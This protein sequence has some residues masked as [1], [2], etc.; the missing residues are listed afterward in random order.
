MTNRNPTLYR[1]IA[2]GSALS[3][4]FA[5]GGS[6]GGGRN[7]GRPSGT[8]SFPPSDDSVTDADSI[9]VR[10]TADDRRDVTGVTVNGVVATTSDTFAHWEA[11]VPLVSTP[12]ELS[13]DI[14]AQGNR[15]RLDAVTRTIHVS[16]KVL[17]TPRDV[18]LG[19]TTGDL[20]ILDSFHRGLFRQDLATS[21]RTLVSDD[22]QGTGFAL[23]LP[24][25]ILID[26]TNSRAFLSNGSP[27]AIVEIDLLTGD[28]AEFSGPTRGAG[29]ALSTPADLVLD[30][31]GNRLL[32]TDN[33][34]DAVV[35]IDLATGDRTIF[36]D[37][38][39]DTTGPNFSVPLGITLDLVNQRALVA[40][41]GAAQLMEVDLTSGERNNISGS[42]RGLGDVFQGLAD[43][44]VVAAG[45]RAY[46]T[47]IVKLSIFTVDLATGDRTVLSGPGVGTGPDITSPNGIE[48]LESAQTVIVADGNS[49]SVLQVDVTTGNRASITE[50]EPA[51]SGPAL[52]SPRAV[53]VDE[54]SNVLYIAE[55]KSILRVNQATGERT[56]LPGSTPILEDVVAMVFDPSE[57]QLIASDSVLGI[58]SIDPGTGVVTT[59]SNASKGSGIPLETLKDIALDLPEKRLLA[60]ESSSGTPP[61][62]LIAIDLDDGDRVSLSSDV[63]GTGPNFTNPVGLG[64]DGTRKR[65]I[66]TDDGL[67]AVLFVNLTSGDR[68]ILSD[69]GTGGGVPMGSPGDVTVDTDRDRV[70]LINRTALDRQV[71]SVDPVTGER[72]L[73]SANLALGRHM[74]P[75]LAVPAGVA[76]EAERNLLHVTDLFQSSLL[77]V[78]LANGERIIVAH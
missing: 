17:V 12:V 67:D 3:L 48:L 45:D 29:P 13:V 59:I 14:E 42:G 55:Q 8:M 21:E 26:E 6:S 69:A 68:T 60:I 10:G 62:A 49:H 37:N 65:A 71:L 32:I 33:G 47:D 16:G 23:N 54:E 27:A 51:G 78:D 64:N 52:E 15:R 46:A 36:S 43:V 35:A 39:T 31:G 70:I 18:K 57:G 24:R 76:L 44:V 61:I 75:P 22:L 74:G 77:T 20:F 40:D 30:E 38:S 19:L 50:I 25:S 2:A 58:V 66:V 5:C 53:A 1:W 28:R 73:L 72:F 63:Q 9:T 56:T 34:L 4:L 7:D 41:L 11:L